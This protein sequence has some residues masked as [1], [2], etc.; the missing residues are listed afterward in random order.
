MVDGEE[1]L[2]LHHLIELLDA[3]LVSTD[4]T[5][6][7]AL[8]K[9]LFIAALAMDDGKEHIP[10]PIEK[11]LADIQARLNTLEKRT[12]LSGSQQ[13]TTWT[14]NTW[15]WYVPSTSG[16]VSTPG[17]SITGVSINDYSKYTKLMADS[18]KVL[19]TLEKDMI[20]NTTKTII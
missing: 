13:G 16:Y 6:R 12:T 8:K 4:P 14:D 3:A 2:D 17:T 18:Y 20:T 11:I 5:V 7:K 1:E 9:F 15:K 19:E 10:G